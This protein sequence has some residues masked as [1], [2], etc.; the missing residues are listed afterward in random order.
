MV[1]QSSPCRGRYCHNLLY[2]YRILFPFFKPKPKPELYRFYLLK[3]LSEFCDPNPYL[4]VEL[5]LQ[6]NERPPVSV[7][8]SENYSWKLFGFNNNE[9]LVCRRELGLWRF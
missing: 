8:N 6:P 2:R 7:T 4:L 1:L 5:C 9:L 3:F